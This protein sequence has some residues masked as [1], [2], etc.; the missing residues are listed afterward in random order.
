[1]DIERRFWEKVVIEPRGCW[2]W[3]GS[4]RN[5][6]GQF[7]VGRVGRKQISKRAHRVVWEL[8]Y[9]E[10][11]PGEGYHGTCVLH[12][13]DNPG[14]VNP[15]HLFLGSARD[16]AE[17]AAAKG[18]MGPR[19]EFRPLR[20]HCRRGHRLED[21]NVKVR[22]DGYRECLSCRRMWGRA[23]YWKKQAAKGRVRKN[24]TRLGGG[25]VKSDWVGVRK[26]V[27]F[28]VVGPAGEGEP[29]FGVE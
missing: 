15:G 6:Y 10:I 22:S 25:R 13:C 2:E 17:D 21:E 24:M 26:V 20:T 12:R 11:P 4:R 19:R 16:N 27:G 23:H 9:G 28:G 7:F 14:C 3:A 29:E 18:R 5:G 1:M 8:M